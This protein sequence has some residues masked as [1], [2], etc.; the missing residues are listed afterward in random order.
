M[1]DALLLGSGAFWTLT[2]VLIIRRG[3]L[4]GTYGMPR[5]S[6]C[7]QTSPRS[8]SSPSSTRTVP[9]SVRSTS[10]GSPWIW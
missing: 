3:F 7:A 6:R 5:S 9:F 2:Y 1:F 4:D 10:F 8:S